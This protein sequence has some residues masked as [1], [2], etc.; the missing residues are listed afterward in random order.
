LDV[1]VL[2][3]VPLL[4]LGVIAALGGG[5]SLGTADDLAAWLRPSRPSVLILGLADA[6]DDAWSILASFQNEPQVRPVAM[7][8]TFSEAVAARALR[9]RAAHVLPRDADAEHLRRVVDEATRGVLS[10]SI[11]ALRTTTALPHA[12]R[13]AAPPSDEE[14]SW[15]RALS[16]G[17]TVTAIAE[18]THLSERVLYRRLGRLYRKLGVEGRT[19]ALILGRDE[20]WL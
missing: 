19:Q 9:V 7:L 13:S 3:A 14:L 17:D 16:H 2:N 12:S 20:G 5:T 1:A 18:A 4:R 8:A 11:V 10:L 6:D 15:L